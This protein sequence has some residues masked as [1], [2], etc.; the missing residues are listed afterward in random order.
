MKIIVDGKEMEIEEPDNMFK[1]IDGK[2]YA[3]VYNEK[4]EELQ[5]RIDKAIED[6][7]ED[8]DYWKDA[9]YVELKAEDFIKILN[10]YLEILEGKK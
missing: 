7:K 4:T 1:Q 5:A 10:N 8:I 3:K 9:I 6:I 2:W